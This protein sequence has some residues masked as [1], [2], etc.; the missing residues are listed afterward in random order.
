MIPPRAQPVSSSGSILVSVCL[1]A[2]VFSGMRRVNYYISSMLVSDE[3]L[4]TKSLL[5]LL[6]EAKIELDTEYPESK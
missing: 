6:L 4:L 3:G 1:A 2:V 5:D